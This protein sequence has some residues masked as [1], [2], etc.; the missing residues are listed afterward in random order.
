LPGDVDCNAGGVGGKAEAWDDENDPRRIS[1]SLNYRIDELPLSGEAEL[2]PW[3][4]SYW[5]TYH[6][7]TNYRWQGPDTLSPMEKYDVVFHGWEPPQDWAY[8]DD[9]PE[10]CGENAQELYADYVS[11]LGP[12]AQIQATAQGRDRLFDGIDNDDD[13]EVDECGASDKD[14]IETWWGLCHA[15]APAAIMEPEPLK[16][17]EYEGVR[18]EVSDIK[19]LILVAYDGATSA[20]LGG[21]CNAKEFERDANERIE[22]DECRDV[23]AGAWHVIATNF[24]GINKRS[25]VEDRTIGFEVWNQP[26]RGY[27]ITLQQDVNFDRVKEL[28]EFEDDEYPFNDD[29]VRFV[30]VEMKAAYITEG[31][32]S[33]DALGFADYTRNDFYHYILEINDEGKIIGGEWVGFSKEDHPDFLWVPLRPRTDFGRRGNRKLELA[34]VRKLLQ[35]SLED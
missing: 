11:T 1:E 13:G 27:E 26:M 21:R 25:F 5:P 2:V 18:F 34:N 15:W 9:V 8:A 35:L 20:F 16:A 32:Q 17:V 23:N 24:L 29:A 3:A 19:A 33:T 28:L 14:G 12:S 7:S 22:A 31:D 10:D 4:A 6:G 30:E